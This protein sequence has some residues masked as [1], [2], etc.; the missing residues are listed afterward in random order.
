M[1][2]ICGPDSSFCAFVPSA[3]EQAVKS[4]TKTP[5]TIP[6]FDIARSSERGRDTPRPRCL[7]PNRVPV[8]AR[9]TNGRNGRSSDS[10]CINY[11]RPYWTSGPPGSAPLACGRARASHPREALGWCAVP[12]SLVSFARALALARSGSAAAAAMAI[13]LV[14]ACATGLMGCTSIAYVT[15]AAAG[16]NDLNQR[17]RDIDLLLREDR[18]DGRLHRLLG[19]VTAIKRFGERH[20]LTATTN[21]EKFVKV[22]RSAVVWVVSASEP[23]R[24]HSKTW[25]FPLV[26]SFNALNWFKKSEAD[27][28]AA[29]LR[30]EGWDVDVRGASAYSTAGYFED[31]VLSTMIPKSKEAL[32]GLAN[33]ILHESSH[34]TIFVR[35]QSTLNESVANFVGDH[36]ANLYL[37]ETM[38]E[39]GAET[40]AYRAAETRGKKHAQLMRAAYKELD[41]LFAS[42]VP[43]DEKRARKQAIVTELRAR[44][45]PGRPINNA[46]LIQFRTYNSGQEELAQLLAACS[47]DWL[48]F[49]AA[50]KGLEKATF[51]KAQDPDVARMLAPLVAA[52]CSAAPAE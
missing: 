40:V 23:L 8:R 47:G 6:N 19:Q 46:T 39:D 18:V 41:A 32:G 43:S 45:G 35:H 24:F 34:A 27:A 52:G 38:G 36:L 17:A 30:E 33:T 44:L 2:P 48:R 31:A 3:P 22:D 50:V 7:Y 13:A 1:E 9:K 51:A 26:G 14:G 37:E 12:S 49:V 15:Q 20:G 4:P 25:T 28:F 29:S 10:R 5:H 11:F 16:Q 42:P 21:Y